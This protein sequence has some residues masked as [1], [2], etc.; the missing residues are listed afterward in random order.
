MYSYS[1]VEFLWCGGI[2]VI[3]TFILGLFCNVVLLLLR[4]AKNMKVVLGGRAS[5]Q[6]LNDYEETSLDSE[7]LSDF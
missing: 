6:H 3:N 4:I 1:I 5:Y 2:L 7:I